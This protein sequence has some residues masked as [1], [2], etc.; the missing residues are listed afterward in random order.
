M[1]YEALWDTVMTE[2]ARRRSV[3]AEAKHSPNFRVIRAVVVGRDD[4]PELIATHPWSRDTVCVC[5]VTLRRGDGPEPVR[6]EGGIS[7]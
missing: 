5:G 6:F 3:S 1:K 2:L 4:W 7:L